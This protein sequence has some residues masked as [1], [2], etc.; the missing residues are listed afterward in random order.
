M[1]GLTVLGRMAHTGGLVTQDDENVTISGGLS[2]SNIPSD[3]LKYCSHL[4]LPVKSSQYPVDIHTPPSN[5]CNE[6][7]VSGTWILSC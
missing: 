2:V 7:E 4:S 5:G 3:G 6:A 1:T